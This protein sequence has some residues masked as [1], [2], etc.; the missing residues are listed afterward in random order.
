MNVRTVYICK[1]SFLYVMLV[2][3]NQEVSALKT[4]TVN[5]HQEDN[6]KA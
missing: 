4:F 6:A 3:Y 2:L 5:F 1:Q